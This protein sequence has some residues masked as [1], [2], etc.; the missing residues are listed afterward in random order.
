M[1]QLRSASLPLLLFVPTSLKLFPLPKALMIYLFIVICI[2]QGYLPRCE[3]PLRERSGGH[4]PGVAAYASV[5]EVVTCLEY[6][7]NYIGELVRNF[8]GTQY[9]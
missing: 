5:F 7:R 4:R 9:D 3:E 2:T 6:D 1:R 8:V